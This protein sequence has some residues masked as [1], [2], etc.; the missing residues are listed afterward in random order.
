MKSRLI[1][2]TVVAAALVGFY[3]VTIRPLLE[4][5]APRL[6]RRVLK[7]FRAPNIAPPPLPAPVVETPTLRPPLLDVPAPQSPRPL[8]ASG[9]PSSLEVPI[10][11][12]ATIDFSIGAPVVRSTPED[13]AALDR[14]LRDMEEAARSIT[15]EP[16]PKKAE[17]EKAEPAK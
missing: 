4:P 1:W 11:E 17:P 12:R 10:Q 14:A 9:Q 6:N 3:Y 2:L 13:Q 16:K 15:F 7:E 8:N 5:A